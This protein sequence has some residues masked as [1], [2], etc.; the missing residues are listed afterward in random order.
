LRQCIRPIDS[1]SFANYNIKSTCF[2]K[3]FLNDSLYLSLTETSCLK[4]TIF[5]GEY[6][7]KDSIHFIDFVTFYNPSFHVSLGGICGDKI[8]RDQL[9]QIKKIVLHSSPFKVSISSCDL[10]IQKDTGNEI[11]KVKGSLIPKVAM[12]C[13]L[14]LKENQHILL[15]NVKVLT[16]DGIRSFDEINYEIKN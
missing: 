4:K 16:P 7:S 9:P 3:R 2:R 6:T 14:K 11:F 15:A 13:I 1:A 8:T 12:D 10:Y 5:L